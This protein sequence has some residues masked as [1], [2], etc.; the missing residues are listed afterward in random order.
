M[1]N[2]G[3]TCLGAFMSRLEFVAGGT[4]HIAQNAVAALLRVFNF[5]YVSYTTG[6]VRS[7]I[8]QQA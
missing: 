7:P 3:R 2:V 1:L 6:L 4:E 5:H 8:I